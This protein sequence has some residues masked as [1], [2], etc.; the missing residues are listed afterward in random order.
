M[1]GGQTAWLARVVVIGDSWID[2]MAAQRAGA[3]FIGFRADAEA[4][5]SRGIKPLCT[6]QQLGE[7]LGLEL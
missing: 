3:T 5:D 4:L 6:V 2:G 1:V 7:L